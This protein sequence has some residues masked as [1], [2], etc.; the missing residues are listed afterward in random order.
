MKQT[1]VETKRFTAST[2]PSISHH[3]IKQLID[4]ANG[5]I[6]RTTFQHQIEEVPSESQAFL[7][8]LAGRSSLPLCHQPLSPLH[9][10][11][12]DDLCEDMYSP[13]TW[14]WKES[15]RIWHFICLQECGGRVCVSV[16]V[17][18]A[19]ELSVQGDEVTAQSDGVLQAP[20]HQNLSGPCSH[21]SSD[22]HTHRETYTNFF[23]LLFNSSFL[24]FASL[25]SLFTLESLTHIET[26]SN[27]LLSHLRYHT[28]KHRDTHTLPFKS[29][30]QVSEL[31]FY[32]GC[33]VM[34][35]QFLS[36]RSWHQQQQEEGFPST[37]THTS[38]GMA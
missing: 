2:N 20:V 36:S 30:N 17:W 31:F 5:Q 25:P 13:E 7:S 34:A 28:D 22:T 16:C 24:V 37:H 32:P 27:T 11:C 9:P 4:S 18:Q 33:E 1:P 8:Y 6:G 38:E 21:L 26:H 14:P 23:H 29:L 19:D 15:L 10:N 3:N 35:P 12:D